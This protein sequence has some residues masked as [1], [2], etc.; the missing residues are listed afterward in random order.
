MRAT[1]KKSIVL[2]GFFSLIIGI[3]LI[4]LPFVSIPNNTTQAYQI[5]KSE[6]IVGGWTPLAAVAPATSMAKGVELTAGDSLNIQVNATFGKGINFYV[7]RGVIGLVY[8]YSGTATELSYQNV[9][10]VNKGWT[11]PVS[12]QYSF[13]FNSSNLFSYKDVSVLVTKQWNETAYRDVTQ[14]VQ[15]LPFE[16]VYVGAVIFLC[17]LAITIFGVI[18]R[19]IQP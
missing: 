12:S 6:V 10:T 2:T 14:K 11:V 16:A 4:T 13:V 5:P 1:M 15:L 17:G 3:L 7:N 9:T 18:K 8:P 19:R